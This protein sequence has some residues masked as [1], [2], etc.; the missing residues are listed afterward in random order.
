LTSPIAGAT[1]NLGDAIVSPPLTI[2]IIGA[3]AQV[4]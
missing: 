4:Y 3:V 2:T 1:D